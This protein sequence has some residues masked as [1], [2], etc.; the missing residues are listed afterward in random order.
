MRKYIFFSKLAKYISRFN[1][2]ILS[3]SK[4]DIYVYIPLRLSEST[5]SLVVEASKSEEGGGAGGRGDYSSSTFL[6]PNW[7]SPLNC[8]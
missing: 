1:S 2:E 8:N 7:S 6:P 4:P 5:Y 3:Q